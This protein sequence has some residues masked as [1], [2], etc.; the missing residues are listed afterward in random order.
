MSF[1][2]V[3]RNGSPTSTKFGVTLYLWLIKCSKMIIWKLGFRLVMFIWWTECNNELTHL[4][5]MELS[6][7]N[8][9]TSISILW[10]LWWYMCIFDYFHFYGAYCKQAVETLVRCHIGVIWVCTV[11]LCLTKRTHRERSGSVVECLTRKRGA[12]GLSLTG[13]TALWFLSKTH[14]S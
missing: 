13:V 10:G 7:L 9:M 4:S 11:F 2:A 1:K 14:L 3:G 12:A 8:N 5:R 6:T